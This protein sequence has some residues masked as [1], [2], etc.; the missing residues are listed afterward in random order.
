M[1]QFMGSQRVEHDRATKLNWVKETSEYYQLQVP[2]PGVKVRV[3][4][5]HRPLSVSTNQ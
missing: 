4:M 1:L 3:E 5:F 2:P